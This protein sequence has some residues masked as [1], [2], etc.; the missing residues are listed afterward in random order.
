MVMGLISRLVL[1]PKK[2][3]SSYYKRYLFKFCVFFMLGKQT[4]V[5]LLWPS[6]YASSFANKI[7]WDKV[8]IH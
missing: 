1:F 6:P 7:V 3:P 5:R 2:Y 4:M 8:S